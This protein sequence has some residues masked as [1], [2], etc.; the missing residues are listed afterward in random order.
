M[1]SFHA[2]KKDGSDTLCESLGFL[3]HQVKVRI[4]LVLSICK[5]NFQLF[6]LMV[7]AYRMQALPSF[8]CQ[9][10]KHKQHQCFICGKLGSSDKSR[11]AEV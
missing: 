8:M 4:S 6:A 11:C 7:N 2:T 5:P 10:C 1:R 9:N 3:E